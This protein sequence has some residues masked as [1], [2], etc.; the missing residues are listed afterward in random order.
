M[1][2]IRFRSVTETGVG[3][4]TRGPRIYVDGGVTEVFVQSMVLRERGLMEK[5]G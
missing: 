5:P 4:K 1:V 3:E 2:D